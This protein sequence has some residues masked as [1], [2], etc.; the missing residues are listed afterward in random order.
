MLRAL[1]RIFLIAAASLLCAILASSPI[2]AQISYDS[3]QDTVF[4]HSQ[5][6]PLWI[7]G[8]G[9]FIFQWHPRFP[10]AYSGAHSFEHAS[11][12]AASELITLYTGLELDPS[13]ETV[14]DI[15]SAGG[16]GLSQVLGLAGFTNLDAV[17]NPELS[18]KPYV[19]RFWLRKVISLSK[20]TL[21]VERTPLSMLTTLPVRRLDIHLGKFDMVDFFDL[22]SVANDSHMQFMNWTVVNNGAY[23]YAA[24]TRGYT[25]GGVIDYEDRWW[26]FR[27]AEALVSKRANGLNLQK[28]LQDAHSEN[29]EVELRPELIENRSTVIRLL[30]FTNFANM[31]DY[32]QAI[33][34][35]AQGVTHVPDITAH[36]RR[37][38]LKYGFGVNA[39]Q[40]FNDYLRGFF[41][42][43]WNEGQHESFNYT[44]VN[45][46]IAFGGDLR[47]SLWNRSEDKFGV[48]FV[49]NGISRRHRQYL[50]LGGLGFLLG[51]GRLT[52]GPEKIMECYYNFPIPV[53]A[54]FYGA[55][56]LQYIDN[57]GYNR[58]R[59]PVIVPG[60]RLH[61]EL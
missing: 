4:A 51:D 23:D 24:D 43:G 10:A 55:L 56:D 60:M 37:T 5:T 35:F 29:Y 17:R 61:V 26:G 40:E 11:E 22:N 41:R 47:G 53:H 14:L 46:T 28:N 49:G 44:E 21:S 15:E 59:G 12:Q 33:D 20:D 48:A 45:Q 1:V 34:L 16:S 3:G 9:N 18:A 31:G 27:F 58:D 50:G 39:E 25:Y 13:T 54:G 19:A 57:P 7:S 52:Y 32:H 36:P 30:G 8:Q 2:L 42:A 6:L 38:K